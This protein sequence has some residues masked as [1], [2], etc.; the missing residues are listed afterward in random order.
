MLL[1]CALLLLLLFFKDRK[2]FFLIDVSLLAE[3]RSCPNPLHNLLNLILTNLGQKGQKS[4]RGGGGEGVIVLIS[5][6]KRLEADVCRS[7]FPPCL[8][9]SS[10][11][12][13]ARERVK[14]K[15]LDKVDVLIST[16]IGLFQ[17]FA[18]D[19]IPSGEI[20]LAEGFL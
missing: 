7:F 17:I 13:S 5:E 3:G 12:Q 1:H 16:E 9:I 20:S 10:S 2:Q 11:L 19:F 14:G 6:I 4:K 18:A 15:A 8:A